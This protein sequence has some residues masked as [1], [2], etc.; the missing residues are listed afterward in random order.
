MRR[1]IH[2][3]FLVVPLFGP[4]ALIVGLKRGLRLFL[5]EKLLE[6][7][8]VQVNVA[9]IAP[10]IAFPMLLRM[11]YSRSVRAYSALTGYPVSLSRRV[12]HIRPSAGR[13]GVPRS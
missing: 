3:T 10:Q 4:R 1:E 6:T 7:L 2:F 9:R 13:A 5:G 8:H 12:G 11:A